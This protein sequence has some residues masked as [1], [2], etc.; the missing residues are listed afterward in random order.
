MHLL[1]LCK[2]LEGAKEGR[3]VKEEGGVEESVYVASVKL[4]AFVCPSPR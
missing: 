3:G 2:T 1:S 4:G